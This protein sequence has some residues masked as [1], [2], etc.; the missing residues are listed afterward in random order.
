VVEVRADKFAGR[1][2]QACK[3]QGDRRQVDSDDPRRIET[4]QQSEILSGAAADI[5]VPRTR[6]GAE[7]LQ[8]IK[9]ELSSIAAPPV[10][11]LHRENLSIEFWLHWSGRVLNRCM[12]YQNVNRC[13]G[14]R[15]MPAKL[16]SSSFV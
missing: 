8:E 11:R 13:L 6:A 2:G 15:R 1:A 4:I 9:A 16:C 12:F 7:L 14:L 5:E 10:R 3:F